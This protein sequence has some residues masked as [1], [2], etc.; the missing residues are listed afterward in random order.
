MSQQKKGIG[1]LV[2][3]IGV[4]FGDI[5]TSP[6]YAL[7]ETFAGHH[8]IPVTP[9]N[10]FGVLSLVFWTVMLLVT[11]KYVIVIMRADNHGEGGSLALLALVTEL[12]R[13]R[14]VHYPLMMLGVIA[15]A[16]FYGDSM[17]T[18]AISVLSAV[19]GLEVVTPDLKAYVVPITAVVLTL[20]FAIQSRGTGLVGRLFGP[21]MCM[22]F[23]TLALLGIANIVHAPEV[24]E[25]ISPTFAIEFVFRHPLMSF[26][27]LGSV[28]LAVTGGEALYTDM[29]HFGRF[30]IRLAWFGLVLPALL[31]NYF[32]QGA[33]LIHDPSAI[34]NPFFR[35]G[36]EWMVVPMVGLATLATVI[37]SQAVISG[38][39]SVARQ[40]IQL[41]LLPRMTIVHTS[42]EEAGQIYVPFTNWTLYLAVMALVVGF[43]S[44]SN[45]AAAYG[46]AV[47][48]TMM[49]DTILV[50]FVAALLWRWHPAVVAVVIGTLLLLDFAFFAANIIKV[51]QGGW[52]PLFIGFIS[53]TVLT[54]WRRGRAL[55]RKQLKKQAVP[56]DVVL[57]ALGPNVSRAR[58][59]AVFLT[60]ATD[61]VPPALL[62]NLKH[63]Q[64]V[65]QRVILTTVS[66]AETPYVP[67]SERVH[68]TDI[69]DGF[70][71]LII[72]YG[73]MQTPDVPAAL[74]LC[75]QFGHEFNMMSTSFFLSRETYVPSLNPGM[76]LWRERLFTFM[77][78]NATR[79]TTFFKIPTD[80]VVEL[81]TQL[82][83]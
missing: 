27:A 69:G 40:A 25:A 53:F 33:L 64:T 51:A 20:L 28:V 58:G 5:G 48:G 39:Y 9:D 83:I 44:S 16:L 68:M 30:P 7:K 55:V 31:L 2:S 3:A 82:E 21:V 41:G 59:T 4:V 60:A 72:R 65:H 70:H 37:A 76:A 26:Y 46:I 81:G 61:G 67:D 22:W 8:P 66:T 42:G 24:L 15:A 35:L 50:S 79:A 11:V 10:I 54:T 17:I 36:P 47:T 77:T 43:Q 12:T 56:L 1:L 75:K 73:F 18:P 29:G 14:R 62:H 71:R 52:F 49:I 63:N 23:L 13:G 6:L 38:A 32:G 78:L 34:Q 45:L 80:R 19:E 57:R 74:S